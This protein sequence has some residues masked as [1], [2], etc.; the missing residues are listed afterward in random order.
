MRALISILEL[1]TSAALRHLHTRS[2]V[3]SQ[4]C[5]CEDVAIVASLPHLR[6]SCS[7]KWRPIGRIGRREVSRVVETKTG[8]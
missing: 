4:L 8:R 5:S 7:G 1:I 6:V 3:G 2:P